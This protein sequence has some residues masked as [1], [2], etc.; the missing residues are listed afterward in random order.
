[1]LR[2][3]IQASA[4]HLEVAVKQLLLEDSM[5]DQNERRSVHR[6]AIVRPVDLFIRATGERLKAFSRNI[7]YQGVSLITRK[8]ILSGT[9]AKIQIHRLNCEPS[10]FLTECRWAGSF[11]SE[12]YVSGWNFL[13]VEEQKLRDY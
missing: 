3:S 5:F 4:T 12:W 8:P 7:S 10:L 2:D 13:N 11:G 9:I 1:M 6:E